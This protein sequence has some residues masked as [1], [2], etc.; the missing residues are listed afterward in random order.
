MQTGA[1][2][3]DEFDVLHGSVLAYNSTSNDVLAELKAAVEAASDSNTFT[4]K[5]AAFPPIFRV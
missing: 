5:S 1:E 4:A 3:V 2:Q